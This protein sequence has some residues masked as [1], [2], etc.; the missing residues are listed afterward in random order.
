MATI[1]SKAEERAQKCLDYKFCSGINLLAV[2]QKV[3][4][5]LSHMRDSGVFVE[6]TMHDISH[7]NGILALYEKI[8]P[9]VTKER[10]TSADWLMIVLAAYFHDIGMIVTR[11]E[12]DG[13]EDN[14]DFRTFKEEKMKSSL[15]MSE[16]SALSPENQD[17]FWYQEFV[18]SEHGN[19]AHDW[20]KKSE[21][22]ESEICSM[23]NEVLAGL[24]DSFRNSLALICKSHTLDVLPEDLCCVDEAYG[25][26]D[27]EKVNLLYASVLL[28]TADLLHVTSDRTPS[29]D[30][31]IILPQNRISQL[32]WAKQKAVKAIDVKEENDENG[33]LS[34]VHSHSFTIQAKFNDA[35]G[36]FSFKDYVAYAQDELCKCRKWIQAEHSEYASK[37]L[38]PWD[39]IDTSRIKAEGFST[40]KLRFDIDQK[41]ILNLLTGHTLYNNTTVVLRE[42]IQNAIDAGRLQ[43]ALEKE[44]SKYQSKVN[45]SWNS[46]TRK[47][48]ISDNATGMNT[49]AITNYLLRVGSSRY[50]SEEFKKAYPQFHSISRFGIG[51]L[52][53]FM[54]CDD[55]DV[56]TL[57]TVE[58]KC[59]LL[60][61]RNLHGEYLM[62]DDANVSHI[63]E[64]KHGSTFELTV[65]PEINMSD[66]ECQIK[67]WILLPFGEVTLTIDNG[68]PIRIGYNS[69]EDAVT[70]YAQ[71][72]KEVELNENFRVDSFHRNGIEMSCLLKKNPWTDV[73]SLYQIEDDDEQNSLN[74]TGICIE[75]V[76]V[77]DSTPGLFSRDYVAVVNCTGL[78]SPATNVARDALEACPSTDEVYRN[79]YRMYED[80]L[81]E[82]RSV[83]EKKYTKLWAISELNR[84][85]DLLYRHFSQNRLLNKNFF[86]DTIGQLENIVIDDGCNMELCCVDK[87]PNSISTISCMAYKSAV[88][89]LEDVHESSE[90][91]IGLLKRLEPQKISSKVYLS[92]DN[93]SLLCQ[94]VFMERYEVTSLSVSRASHWVQLN[95]SAITQKP[96]WKHFVIESYP[97]SYAYRNTHLFLCRDEKFIM[98]GGDDYN[99]VV[100]DNCCFILKGS[101]LYEYFIKQCDVYA[102]EDPHIQFLSD[103]A[104]GL[105]NERID[106]IDELM[107]HS[108]HHRTSMWNESFWTDSFRRKDLTKIIE[109][110]DLKVINFRA[111]YH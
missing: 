92:M 20:V 37:Y 60:K 38:F 97:Q 33:N 11:A 101:S 104:I 65:R 67:N 36:Y 32:E 22:Y 56:Y 81:F 43:D 62:R 73:W 12:F 1:D 10:M 44:G 78:N 90:T 18:R 99:A 7:V 25:T 80:V 57:E 15:I 5:I 27:D 17:K 85:L 21:T 23:I 41:N 75:G 6:Y 13:R 82:Q 111:F 100:S 66:L 54:I 55:L 9:D 71:Q 87:L 2:K 39:S 95:W 51:L 40:N 31:R 35:E 83:L 47:L 96:I 88:R 3:E 58:S 34:K 68:S 16:I 84:H 110:K 77:T 49:H 109:R 106:S 107:D 53:C 70:A 30:Y 79:V 98:E 93:M 108:Y 28:R 29:E 74:P 105:M 59:H 24:D 42:L 45:I 46:K 14:V 102:D 26:S 76:R 52:T 61:I 48:V 63:L 86:L 19:R 64:Q 50:Q 69:T 72:L 8:I 89:L 94:D 103:L 4:K 91:A